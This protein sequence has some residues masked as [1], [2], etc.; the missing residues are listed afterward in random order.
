MCITTAN[1]L[2]GLQANLQRSKVLQKMRQSQRVPQGRMDHSLFGVNWLSQ[3][4]LHHQFR[5]FSE[6]AEGSRLSILHSVSTLS[7]ACIDGVWSS[8]L[9]EA[10][11]VLWEP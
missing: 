10:S 2:R 5:L 8:Y 1:Q 3:A 4:D 7:F 11:D 6:L 9:R